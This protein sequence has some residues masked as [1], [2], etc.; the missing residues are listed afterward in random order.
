[1]PQLDFHDPMTLWQ[2]VWM[3]V[4]F[5]VLYLLLS[6]WTL[7]RVAA[8]VDARAARI[9]ADLESAREAKLQA[10]A[11]IAELTDATHRAHAEAH[12]EIAAAVARAKEEAQQQARAMNA[13]LDAQ[14]AAAEEQITAARQ[15]ASG[16]LR[17]I[18][19][20]TTQILVGRLT[21]HAAPAEAVDSAVN[22]AFAARGV[23]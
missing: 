17:Q 22:A 9:A 7:P 18:A 20:D 8:V 12:G 21:G 14:L 11:A 1:M 5:A 19:A 6:R 23:S 15:Q 4:I 10:D 3:F 13:R 16:A 2:V